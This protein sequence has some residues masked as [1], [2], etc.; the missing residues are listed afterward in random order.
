M[1]AWRPTPEQ[2]AAVADRSGSRLLSA[3]AGSGKTAVMVERFV[4]AVIEDGV[5]VG[6][7]LAI[8][9]TEKAAAELRE[10]VRRRFSELGRIEEARE[11]DGA[12][13]G[14]IH[15]F[16]GRIL[17]TQPLAAGLDPR[18]TVLDE[19][20]AARVAAVA[21]DRALEA[22]VTQHSDAA[23]DLAAAYGDGPL[24]AMVR[25][26][27]A[28]LRSAGQT[29]PALP[30]PGA[31]PDAAAAR[32]TLME[33]AAAASAE[34]AAGTNGLRVTEALDALGRC[35]ELPDTAAPPLPGALDG[36]DVG[37]GAAALKSPACD[38]YR[39]ALEAY[40][41]AC[42][43]HHA[44]PAVRLV[45]A[46]LGH[47]ADAYAAAKRARAA[48]DF[49]DLELCVRDLLVS[50]PAAARRWR[51]RFALVMVDEFQDTNRVQIE[52]LAALERDNLFAVGDEFQSIYGFRHADVDIFRERRAALGEAGNR[53]L[54]A[55][56]RSEP[57]ILDVVNHAF[58]ALLG[59]SFNPLV[60]GGEREL[61]LFDP[62]GAGPRAELLVTHARGWD[63]HED[64]LGLALPQT[65]PERR[66]EARLVAQRLR[67]EAD[68]GRGHGEMV[69]LV[70]NTAS[71][72]LYEQALEEAGLPTYVVGGRGYWAQEQVRDGLAY[73]RA[74]A[75]PLDEQALFAV[76]AS[77]FCGVGAD[78]LVLLAEAGRATGAGAWAALRDGDLDAHAGGD[79][80]RLAGFARFFAAERARAP[81]LA[82][83]LLLE[84]AVSATGYDLAVLARAGGERRMAN[85]RKLMR[86]AREYEAGEGRDLR[87]FVGYATQ[88][89][90]SEAREGEAALEA[91]DL[92]A[93]R[94]MTIHRAKGLEF[95][96]V[97][98]AD[99][100]KAGSS[101]HPAL[102]VAGDR[103]G[104]RLQSGGGGKTVPALAYRALAAERE[105]RE[106]EEERRLLYVA[107]TRA[108][109][110]LILSGTIDLDSPPADR[111]GGPPFA[112][113]H[114]AL[115]SAP[116]LAVTHSTPETLGA[117]LREAAPPAPAP[118]PAPAE[119]P[120]VTGDAVAAR[121]RPAPRRLSY[122][123]LSDYGRCGYR[124]YLRRVLGLPSVAPPVPVEPVDTPRL[125]PRLRG[126]LAHRLLEELDFAA[127]QRPEPARV[128][129]VAAE[130]GT[131]VEPADAEE[132]CDLVAAFAR[133]PLCARLAAARDV[134]IEA[135][136]AF[137]LD[138][139]DLGPLVT[140]FL[141]VIATEADGTALIVDYKTDRLEGADP[142]EA[143]ERGYA[144]QRRVY[145]LAALRAGAPRA[146]VAY[147][148]L[149]Q[150]ENP[151]CESFGEAEELVA[152]L[153]ATAGGMLAEDWSVTADPHRELC[154]DC[155][156]R[157][158]LCSHPEERTLAPYVTTGVA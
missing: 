111:H 20:A 83:E 52:L 120:A 25:G 48:V 31:G 33:A 147:A 110:R 125:D 109:E 92:D 73:L 51:E 23:I 90:L 43:A 58:S 91:E 32:A 129:A 157:E 105:R 127:P 17:R 116:G 138:A 22:W 4:A 85:L 13:I 45:D 57:E 19:P 8:T 155:P 142:H 70:R 1:S 101:Q 152:A 39:D 59:P 107:A 30:E 21:F 24:S 29:R 106:A 158:R 72:G 117:V 126:S 81:R 2:S 128:V 108:E 60:P 140:G 139:P 38:A 87:G 53:R 123:Q 133:S 71:L 56:F 5:P 99:L 98:V 35:R 62:G 27:H 114:P 44:G 102:L 104:L 54:S 156:G 93:V 141:D 118:D 137:A 65:T 68:A 6:G 103:V 64:A 74:L 63:A 46:L 119:A 143:V 75:N 134:R 14:T 66:A 28:V 7:I 148:F 11:A 9:F 55:N 94:L 149:E 16:C 61:R 100:G 69:V 121:A 113:L 84:R 96:L 78:A 135:P 115:A 82:L 10:R 15:G 124:F 153:A 41:A 122:S 150:P 132:I 146:E 112:W 47:F 18:F 80:E 86:L 76:L 37:R 95:P 50:D 34:L 130:W 42:A 3:S 88:Q 151:V 89:D 36:L 79:R 12:W 154:G 145:A 144:T 49:E 131:T 26:V 97:C 136:F 67:E 77:P 40:R